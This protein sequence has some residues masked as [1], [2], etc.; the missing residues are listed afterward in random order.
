MPGK[1]LS[2]MFSL[3]IMVSL[4]LGACSPGQQAPTAASSGPQP[5]AVIPTPQ[6]IIQTV[7]VPVALE[8][9]P[10]Q[11]PAMESFRATIRRLV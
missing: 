8:P 5:T 3:M 1:R 11:D 2:L 4:V 9:F 10:A 6:T 7:E